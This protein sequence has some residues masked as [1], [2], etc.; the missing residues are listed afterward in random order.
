MM[1]KEARHSRPKENRKE[2]LKAGKTLGRIVLERAMD[3]VE[4]ASRWHGWAIGGTVA[5]LD[6]VFASLDANLPDGWTR[7]MGISLAPFQ[8]LVREGSGW[9]SLDATPAHAGVTL[10]L[11]PFR[12]S[13]LRGGSVWFARSQYPTHGGTI[14]AAW[15]Q[16]NRLLDEG[17]VP[18]ARAAGVQLR[19]P[20]PNDLFLAELPSTVR[21]GLCAFSNAARKSLPLNHEEA[22]SWREFVVAAFRLKT[23]IDRKAFTH[24]LVA[25]GW[26]EES[27]KELNLRFFDQSLLLSQFADEVPAL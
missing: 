27:A 25:E 16:V 3:P 2:I 24:W 18:A 23:I 14:P 5:Q 20:N 1:V 21:D 19:L 15:E 4:V 22:E 11:E 13:Q 17:I 9:Y 26:S 10:S 7:L 12:G 8:S 6:R